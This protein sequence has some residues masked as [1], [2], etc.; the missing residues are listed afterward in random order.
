MAVIHSVPVA[1]AFSGIQVAYDPECP[2]E[3]L[4]EQ[5]KVITS[6]VKEVDA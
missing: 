6:L 4:E 3:G 5:T 1:F 2:G